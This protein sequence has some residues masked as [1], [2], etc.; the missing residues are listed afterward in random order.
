MPIMLR[1]CSL[2]SIAWHRVRAW[3]DNDLRAWVPPS[4]FAIHLFS[5]E[6]TIASEGHDRT[7][8]L[9][10]ERPDLRAVIDLLD[11][12]RRGDDLA[13]V[14]APRCRSYG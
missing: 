3:W 2:G 14:G 10:E 7:L 5:V 11:G 12:Q 6:R 13:R 1:R 9:I 4:Y 8:Y